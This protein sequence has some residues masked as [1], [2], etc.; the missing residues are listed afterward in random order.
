MIEIAYIT[1]NSLKFLEAKEGFKNSGIALTQVDID[2]PEIQA[3]DINEVS[4]FSAK[5]AA[6]FLNKPVIL[7]DYGFSI[8]SL[9][10]FPGPFMKFVNK[11]LSPEDFLKLI[12][13]K[14]ERGVEVSF[15]LAF[16]TL[17]DTPLC[18]TSSISGEIATKVGQGTGHS[19]DF[20]FIPQGYDKP[21]SE[22]GKDEMTKFWGNS[23]NS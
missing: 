10:G 22:I 23:F 15:S 5:W 3:F 20:I 11:W 18:F 14:S 4:K 9:N 12:E 21:A 6:D 16:C 19:F 7:S 8:K 13:G 1:G 17:A 2:T